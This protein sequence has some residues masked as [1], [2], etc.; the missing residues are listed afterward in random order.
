LQRRGTTSL[1]TDSAALTE[2]F[3]RP[4]TAVSVEGR[5]LAVA[6]GR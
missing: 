4:I 1:L 3:G 6:G 2:C 5:W